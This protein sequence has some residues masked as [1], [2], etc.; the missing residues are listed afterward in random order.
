MFSVASSLTIR[1]QDRTFRLLK[2]CWIVLT[3]WRGC[4]PEI[5]DDP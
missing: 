3:F 5:S 2:K 1:L 4:G